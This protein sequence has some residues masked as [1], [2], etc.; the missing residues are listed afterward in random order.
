MKSLIYSLRLVQQ[1]SRA[2][3]PENLHQAI[4]LIVIGAVRE[5]HELVDVGLDPSV[6]P[7]DVHDGDAHLNPSQHTRGTVDLVP[8]GLAR[9]KVIPLVVR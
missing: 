6:V 9:L 2:I 3:L 7:R 5:V 8:F 4:D 1:T